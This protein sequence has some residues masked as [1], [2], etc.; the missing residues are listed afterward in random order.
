M[1]RDI[2][3][4]NYELEDEYILILNSRLSRYIILLKLTDNIDYE[5]EILLKIIV[6][7]IL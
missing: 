7:K 6:R 3:Q 5:E 2:L 1:G 4:S